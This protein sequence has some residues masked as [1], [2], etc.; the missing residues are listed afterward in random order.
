MSILTTVIHVV[1]QA[2][3]MVIIKEKVIKRIQIR[4]EKVILSSFADD[5]IQYIRNP[6]DSTRKVLELIDEFGKVAGYKINTQNQ[7]HVSI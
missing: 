7:L 1:L 5:M 4:K 3:T 6:K 2:L